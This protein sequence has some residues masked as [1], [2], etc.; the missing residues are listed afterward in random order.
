MREGAEA[1]EAGESEAKPRVG[2]E[3]GVRVEPGTGRVTVSQGLGSRRPAPPVPPPAPPSTLFLQAATPGAW[4]RSP[5]CPP[6]R[7]QPTMARSAPRRMR[8]SRLQ[9]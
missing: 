4:A 1:G 7:L 8:P 5:H 6:P 3:D 2:T 9:P